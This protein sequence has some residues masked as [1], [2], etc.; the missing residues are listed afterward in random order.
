MKTPVETP[1]GLHTH[2]KEFFYA[3]EAVLKSEMAPIFPIAFLW[4]RTI[5][6][7][8]KSFLLCEGI[9]IKALR[10]KQYGHNLVALFET[11]SDKGLKELIGND[12]IFKALVD[13][14]NM[15][16]ESKRFE[17][18]LTGARYIIPDQQGI[19][20]LIR[21]LMKGINFHLD[22]NDI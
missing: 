16:Y 2:A 5:E 8:L 12:K 21:R 22:K 18:R 19:R 1:R 3:A 13:M 7:L 20:R 11:A 10:S 15:D 9:P 6:L 4:G 14:Q 17:Y